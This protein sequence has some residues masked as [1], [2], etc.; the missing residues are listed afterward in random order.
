[1]AID[2]FDG[3]LM[4]DSCLTTAYLQLDPRTTMTHRLTVCNF[5]VPL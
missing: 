1:M 5:A 4:E 2:T 3:H